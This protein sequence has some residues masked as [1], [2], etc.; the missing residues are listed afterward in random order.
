MIKLLNRFQDM[1][2]ITRKIDFLGPLALRLYLVP[3]FWMAGM[4]KLVDMPSVIDWFGNKEYGLG[5]PFPFLLAWAATLAEIV[6]AVCLLFGFAVRWICIPLLITMAVAAGAAHWD[7]GWLAISEGEGFFATER[8]QHAVERLNELKDWLEKE[9]PERLAAVSEYGKLASLNNGIEFAVTYFVM[10]LMLF[11][12]GA[13]RYFSLDYW[14]A[15]IF[16][17]KS[18]QE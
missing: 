2:D 4:H 8:T 6:G 14:I 16:R 3:I 18:S 5:L 13:G 1:L 9:H 11:F 17:R 15:L 12:V 7:N 10:L